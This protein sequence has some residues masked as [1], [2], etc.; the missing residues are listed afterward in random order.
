MD[1]AGYIQDR[2]IERSVLMATTAIEDSPAAKAV[3]ATAA[4][5]A[6]DTAFIDAVQRAVA[7]IR[8]A[9]AESSSVE[10]DY[11]I[12]RLLSN[13]ELFD[14]FGALSRGVGLSIVGT[15][16]SD[17]F[18][19]LNGLDELVGALCGSRVR[20]VLRE[21][22]KALFAFVGKKRA[23]RGPSPFPSDTLLRPSLY[24]A[25]SAIPPAVMRALLGRD[26]GQITLAGLMFAQE[27]ELPKARVVEL[28]ERFIENQG[29]WLEF[30]GGPLEVT[31]DESA[32][33][34]AR[35]DFRESALQMAKAN[36]A[37]ARAA[38]LLD[39]TDEKIYCFAS[40]PDERAS[41]TKEQQR[42]RYR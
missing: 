17:D 26:I 5:T 23:K 7:L 11:K 15:I 10:L 16:S 22:A 33:P 38:Q 42:D 13:D 25:E 31:V 20:L 18:D 39:T 27:W 3:G 41:D 30:L 8:P 9:V 24:T 19:V 28:C 2:V 1:L 6:I 14:L 4:A 40:G 37:I 35:T 32:L 34:K 36:D 29:L 12:D 21:S